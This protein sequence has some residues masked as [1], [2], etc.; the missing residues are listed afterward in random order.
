MATRTGPQPFTISSWYCGGRSRPS[1]R[2]ARLITWKVASMSRTSSTSRI[3]REVIQ[4]QGHRGSN[5]KSARSRS[6]MGAS[7]GE[8]VL[9]VYR[10]GL[11]LPPR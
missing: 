3:Q 11:A 2:T 1:F 7:E 9:V 5:Q 8:T 10:V 6:A 4:H